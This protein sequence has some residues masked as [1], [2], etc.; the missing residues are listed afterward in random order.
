MTFLTENQNRLYNTV[1]IKKKKHCQGDIFIIQQM[2]LNKLYRLIGMYIN[3]IKIPLKWQKDCMFELW[4][5]AWTEEGDHTWIFW[6]T[7]NSTI[8]Q[9]SVH[10]KPSHVAGTISS[11][12]TTSKLEVP[13]PSCLHLWIINILNLMLFVYI[14]K[15]K[16]ACN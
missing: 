1:L 3:K 13:H 8:L 6:Q 4:L 5:H 7:H 14:C 11:C 2:A 10:P 15:R 12:S 9:R 16:N